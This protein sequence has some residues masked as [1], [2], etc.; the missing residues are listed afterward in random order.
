MN[1]HN[2]LL[3]ITTIIDLK[4]QEEM[5]LYG[6]YN[7]NR[8]LTFSVLLYIYIKNKKNIKLSK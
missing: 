8:R 6:I 7:L 2:M 3:I 1:I 4:N 5:I